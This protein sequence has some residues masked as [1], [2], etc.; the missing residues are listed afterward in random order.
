MN[1]SLLD[2]LLKRKSTGTLRSLQVPGDGIDFFSNDYIGL[3][4]VKISGH[5]PISNGAT[6]SRLLSG[7]SKQAELCEYNLAT[8]FK[9]E[10]AL[11]YNSG[12]V[13]NLGLLS[14]ILQR[15]DEVFYDEYIHASSR[16]GIRLSFS[17]STA[18]K[19]NDVEDLRFK[20]KKSKAKIN[21]VLIE[22]LYSMDGDIAP[23]SEIANLCAINNAYL[24]VDEAHAGGVYGLQGKGLCFESNIS[25]QVFARIITFGKAYGA[26]GA[27]VLG[28]QTLKEFLINFSRGFIYSTALPPTF[29]QDIAALVT[30]KSIEESIFTLKKRIHYFRERCSSLSFLSAE[31]SP[32]QILEFNN[33]ELLEQRVEQLKSVGIH[34]KGIYPPTVPAGKSRLR[35]CLHSY[36]TEKEID[37]LAGVLLQ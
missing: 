1:E 29:Y 3:S 28:S 33:K 22:S 19:H 35:L 13:A 4:Q 21:Y 26:H 14:A 7:N 9:S 2:K 15:E 32:I 20:L 34:T 37:I 8:H 31:T 25:P 12:Y 6:G 16:D 18:F 27:V 36:N 23:L 30:H 17:K 10:S 11:V 5:T 24:I